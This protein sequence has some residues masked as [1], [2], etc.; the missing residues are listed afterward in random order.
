MSRKDTTQTMVTLYTANNRKH[1]LEIN[2]Y[3]TCLKCKYRMMVLI[4][5][6]Y[7]HVRVI[8]SFYLA[9]V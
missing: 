7:G 8:L 4:S 3:N 9:G 1:H 6:I 5:V 2:T